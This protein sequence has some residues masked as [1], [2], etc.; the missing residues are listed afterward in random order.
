MESFGGGLGL[1]PDAEGLRVG[2]LRVCL[3]LLQRAVV[4]S[5]LQRTTAPT[6]PTP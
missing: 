4:S 1:P 6:D 3:L 5:M 2:T